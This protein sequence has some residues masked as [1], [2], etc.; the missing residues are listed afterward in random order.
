M[1]KVTI[2][3]NDYLPAD[4]GITHINIY[5]NGATQLGRFLSNFSF[6]PITTDHG[7]FCSMEGYYHYI[8]SLLAIQH[9]PQALDLRDRYH[10]G[11][12]QLQSLHGKAAQQYGRV[13]RRELMADGVWFDDKTSIVKLEWFITALKSKLMTS[14]LYPVFLESTL[15]F[16][17]YY[18][19]GKN[20]NHKPHYNDLS[21][22]LTTLREQGVNT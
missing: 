5:S 6:S 11:L 9:S 21:E 13:L 20:I 19:Y 8:K 2:N 14:S 16:T 22:V 7:H 15:P 4:D 1:N 10:V 17:H 3:G 12:T 18:V